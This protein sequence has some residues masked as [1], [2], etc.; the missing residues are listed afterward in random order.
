MS[1]KQ[2]S[3]IISRIAL[4]CGSSLFCLL[5]IEIGYRVLDPFRHITSDEINRTEHGNLSEYDQ[6]LGWRGVPEGQAELVTECNSVWLQH[7]RHGFRDVE[8][9]DVGDHWPTIVFLGDSYTWG[10]EVE[11]DEM[12]V[13]KLRDMLPRFNIFNLAHR[14]YGTDQELL[15]FKRWRHDGPI[16][17][18]V[19]MFSENDVAD[20]NSSFRWDK[21]KPKY[22]MIQNE[23][24]LTGVPVPKLADWTDSPTAERKSASWKRRIKDLL[25][26]SHFLHDLSFRTRLHRSSKKREKMQVI[27]D[28]ETDL[29]LTIDILKELKKEVEMRNARL[30]VFFIPSKGE[31]EQL[32]GSPAYQ[33]AVAKL[34][35]KIGIKYFDLAPHFKTTWFRT[36]FRLGMHWN[37]KGHQVAAEAIYEYLIRDVP[38]EQKQR[39]QTKS[40][41]SANKQVR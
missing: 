6:T 24:V 4:L 39:D 23:L 35:E 10:Y 29:T 15:T 11:F 13:N 21:R 37:S 22:R 8:H 27:D 31:I 33:S 40:G 20:N 28:E 12:F 34:C 30:I 18:V 32:D 38:L 16:Q 1:S 36:Y 7:N 9:D 14:G 5:V 41:R 25:Y 26:H 3:Q 19:L 2:R 17:W